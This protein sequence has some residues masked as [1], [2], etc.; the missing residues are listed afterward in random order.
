[1]VI[2]NSNIRKYLSPPEKLS[3]GHFLFFQKCIKVIRASCL[4]NLW[5]TQPTPHTTSDC[6]KGRRYLLFKTIRSYTC[7]QLT[8]DESLTCIHLLN[9]MYPLYFHLH[10][11]QHWP[12]S[13]F[14][15]RKTSK[16]PDV[17]TY[18]VIFRVIKQIGDSLKQVEI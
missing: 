6:V 1:M 17:I 10:F 5:L 9:H 16:L 2:I 13:L 11:E 7:S 18:G 4:F 15:K 12:N 3:I 8:S 14:K